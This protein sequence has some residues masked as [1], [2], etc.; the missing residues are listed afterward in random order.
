MADDRLTIEESSLIVKQ[1]ATVALERDNLRATNKAIV[2]LCAYASKELEGLRAIGAQ[3][4]R[5]A[6]ERIITD[7]VTPEP[8]REPLVVPSV[9]YRPG[10]ICGG[11]KD[12][13]ATD[14][15]WAGREVERLE[16]AMEHG[17]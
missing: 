3:L 16:R 14:S 6:L 10:V 17:D 12:T 15:E 4:A 8:K 1:L 2:D 11:E 13:S 9:Q 7:S 5:A